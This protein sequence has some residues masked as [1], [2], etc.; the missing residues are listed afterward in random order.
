[1]GRTSLTVPYYYL[2]HGVYYLVLLFTIGLFFG[3]VNNSYGKNWNTGSS[4]QLPTTWDWQV[5]CSVD[6][7][8]ISFSKG[9]AIFT[10]SKNRC[11]S[12]G[13]MA[14]RAE[15]KTKK[16]EITEPVQISFQTEFRYSTEQPN[17]FTIFQIHDGR[18]SC[19]PPF[20]VDVDGNGELDIKG[21][22][23]IEPWDGIS[24]YV[25]KCVDTDL[26]KQRFAGDHIVSR[27]GG[28]HRLKVIIDF[29]GE[30]N[31]H[32]LVLLDQQ[33]VL[34]GKYETDEQY[35]VYQQQYFKHGNYSRNLYDYKLVSKYELGESKVDF[36]SLI[37]S[38]TPLD[39]KFGGAYWEPFQNGVVVPEGQLQNEACRD[40]VFASMMGTKC[41]EGLYLNR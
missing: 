14:Q 33:L 8:A 38:A 6:S 13:P 24:E 1:M 40:P 16:I 3:F 5:S 39:T 20:M 9:E 7:G 4:D 22:Y 15:I 32:A 29:D 30:G 11:G 19:A 27:E 34:S 25:E 31:F 28:T 12:V 41:E 36:E 23:Q 17:K 37:S 26:N 2:K 35:Q 18:N 21:G 10:Q